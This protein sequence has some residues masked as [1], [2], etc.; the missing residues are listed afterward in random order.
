[1]S[2]YDDPG[3]PLPQAIIYA[4]EPHFSVLFQGLAVP[5]CLQLMV[6]GARPLQRA[7]LEDPDRP[8]PGVIRV[9]RATFAGTLQGLVEN[10]L[11]P[12]AR[13]SNPD[14][15][16]SLLTLFLGAGG[17]G[18]PARGEPSR[19]A[20]VRPS[21]TAQEVEARAVYRLYASEAGA[22]TVETAAKVFDALKYVAALRAPRAHCPSL[23]C[24]TGHSCS[25]HFDVV[26]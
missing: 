12:A 14:A 22:V 10:H 17:L 1:V 3:A 21:T 6:E 16:A 9:L 20:E 18:V 15:I 8:R 4:Y 26:G 23:R 7:V 19:G 5:E 11:L 24:V 2:T 25:G 13:A